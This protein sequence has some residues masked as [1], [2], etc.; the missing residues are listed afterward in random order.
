MRFLTRGEWLFRRHEDLSRDAIPEFRDLYRRFSL[1]WTDETERMVREHS[2]AGNPEVTADAASHRR[3]S[4]KATT[5]WKRRLD[6]DQIV[7]VRRRP[8]R[9]GGRSTA[10]ATGSE[11]PAFTLRSVRRRLL[12]GSAWVFGARVA[13]L[14]L[15]VVVSALLTRILSKSQVGDY[16]SA[17]TMA[18]LGGA[19]AQL[20]LDRAT[21]RFVASAMGVGQPGRAHAAIRMALRYGTIGALVVAA[22]IALGFG[23]FIADQVFDSPSL[24][25]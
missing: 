12:E 22:V 14:V 3:D 25:P 11:T 9:R 5:A 15:G 1:T 24:P 17:A 20:G 8:S 10:M 2:G 23:R 6:P 21:V 7:R 16:L 18:F 19:I 13:T 4:A